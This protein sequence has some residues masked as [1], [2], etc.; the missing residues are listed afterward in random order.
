M[1]KIRILGVD[2]DNVTLSGALDFAMDML[3]S[4]KQ[5]FVVTPNSEIVYECIKNPALYDALKQA[6]LVLPDGIGVVYASKIYKRPLSQKVAG[7]DFASELCNRLASTHNRLFLLGA[8]PGIAE[9]AAAALTEKYPGLLVCGVKD[10]YFRDDEEAVKAISDS[11]AD[12]VF[13]CLGAP[14]QEFFMKAHLHETNVKLMIGLGGSLDV[15]AGVVR[16]APELFIKLGLEWFYRLI[17]E[18]KRIGRMA[19]LPLFL[20]AAAKDSMKG[21]E[22]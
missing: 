19:R 12:V 6:A 15:F 21:G 3:C 14:K 1:E 11:S 7:I 2:F 17:K 16:R 13:V 20:L 22:K 10:G 18:P 8:K 4:E 9:K 5:G